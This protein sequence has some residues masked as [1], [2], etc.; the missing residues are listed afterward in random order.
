MDED[1]VGSVNIED[2]ATEID[3]L[4]DDLPPTPFDWDD[5]DHQDAL[6][7]YFLKNISEYRYLKKID[8]AEGIHT[9]LGC[10][11]STQKACVE[12]PTVRDWFVGKGIL[13]VDC[14]CSQGCGKPS[15]V[16]DTLLPVLVL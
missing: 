9:L 6:D 2:S 8:N 12:S 11:K 3:N 14:G 10:A 5:R 7:D 13:V 16:V 4:L 1:F 15:I